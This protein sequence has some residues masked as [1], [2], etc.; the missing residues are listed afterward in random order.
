MPPRDESTLWHTYCGP[1][2][3]CGGLFASG[4]STKAQHG[5]HCAGRVEGHAHLH[6]VGIPVEPGDCAMIA[7]IVDGDGRDEALVHQ[8]RQWWLAV[9]RVPAPSC[10]TQQAIY[11]PIERR[12]AVRL[13]LNRHVCMPSIC[14][15]HTRLM[16]CA[17]LPVSLTRCLLRLTHLW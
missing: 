16:T 7:H 12:Q 13:A 11:M 6:F 1:R 3:T 2:T 4:S 8:H 15:P 17:H 5:L 10:P 14:T 9:Q